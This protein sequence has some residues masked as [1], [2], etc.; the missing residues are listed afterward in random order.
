MDRMQRTGLMPPELALARRLADAANPNGTTGAALL[1]RRGALAP[2]EEAIRAVEQAF[3]AGSPADVLRAV[4]TARASLYRVETF[5][6]NG[7][8]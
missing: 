3:S 6:N 2:M 5:M 4:R 8:A 1:R 7:A